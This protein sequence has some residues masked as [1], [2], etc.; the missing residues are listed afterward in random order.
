MT[1]YEDRKPQIENMKTSRSVSQHQTLKWLSAQIHAD[2]GSWR[3]GQCHR[4]ARDVRLLTRRFAAVIDQRHHNAAVAC[5]D[6]PI[7]LLALLFIT[8]N[9]AVPGQARIEFVHL[10]RRRQMPA[11][12]HCCAG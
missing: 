9:I 7:A 8:E 1:D 2:D 12:R 3:R 4:A 11:S 10:P 6:R 5:S